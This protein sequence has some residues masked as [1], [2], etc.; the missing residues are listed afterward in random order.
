MAIPLKQSTGSSG[1]SAMDS[2]YLGFTN[3]ETGSDCPLRHLS[4]E[5]ANLGYLGVRQLCMK[6]SLTRHIRTLT[7]A[8]SSAGVGGHFDWQKSSTACRAD[9]RRIFSALGRRVNL[10]GMLLTRYQLQVLD[11]VIKRVAIAMMDNLILMQHATEML[12][13][14]EAMLQSVA[15]R[16]RHRMKRSTHQAITVLVDGLPSVPT[17]VKRTLGPMAGQIAHGLVVLQTMVGRFTDGCN[18]RPAATAAF[19]VNRICPIHRLIVSLSVRPVR[20][21]GA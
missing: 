11:A 1:F 2:G 14:D 8:K 7:G 20:Q 5:M 6:R 19:H 3:T 16:S 10:S 21:R 9:L 17:G 15:G 18:A 13:H 4:F 12:G